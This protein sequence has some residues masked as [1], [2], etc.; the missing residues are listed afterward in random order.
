MYIHKYYIYIYK[1]NT[2]Y[3]SWKQT[4]SIQMS[5]CRL[6]RFHKPW[7]DM[8]VCVCWRKWWTSPK[9]DGS[10]IRNGLNLQR[11]FHFVGNLN[12]KTSTY[13]AVRGLQLQTKPLPIHVK[14]CSERDKHLEKHISYKYKNQF[15]NLIL[16]TQ[17]VISYLFPRSY[18]CC[19]SQIL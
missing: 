14:C 6:F 12:L 10:G 3:L 18:Y 1:Q 7:V 8:S 17:Q 2:L 19:V 9:F 16:M 11:H 4:K 5:K 15:P 13:V